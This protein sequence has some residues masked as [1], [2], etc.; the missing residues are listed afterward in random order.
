MDESCLVVSVILNLV[1]P[2]A[3]QKQILKNAQMNPLNIKEQLCLFA[4]QLARS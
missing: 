2:S 3:E 1:S 4:L